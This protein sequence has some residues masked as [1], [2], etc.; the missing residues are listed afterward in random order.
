M[1][2][3]KFDSIDEYMT[4]VSTLYPDSRLAGSDGQYSI[5]SSLLIVHSDL[6]KDIFETL[7]DTTESVVIIPDF[8]MCEISTLVRIMYG[9]DD[10]GF[11][12]GG[13]LETLGMK[14]YQTLIVI[15]IEQCSLDANNVMFELPLEGPAVKEFVIEDTVTTDIVPAD[16]IESD[17]DPPNIVSQTVKNS[18]KCDLCDKVLKT[19][20]CS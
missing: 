15:E 10:H 2:S 20:T 11:V 5:H 1:Q 3:I 9:V 17:R 16:S 4:R 12:S 19:I 14:Q 7:N 18:F 6:L 8:N 13:I